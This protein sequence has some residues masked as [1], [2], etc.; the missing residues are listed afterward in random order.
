MKPIMSILFSLQNNYITF[1]YTFN[2]G[3]FVAVRKTDIE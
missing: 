2:L 1:F 3:D